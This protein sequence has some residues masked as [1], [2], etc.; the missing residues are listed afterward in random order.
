MGLMIIKDGVVQVERYQYERQ[1]SHRFLSNSMAKSIISLAIG[2]AL[3]EGKI[4]SLDD[5]ANM[6]APKLEGTLFGETT[7]SNLL[8]MASGARYTEEYDGKDDAAASVPQRLAMASRLLRKSLPNGRRRKDLASTGS[9]QT[10][11]LAA[12]L[13]GATGMKRQRISHPPRMAGN[14]R[15]NIGLMACRQNWP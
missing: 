5:R 14:W 7:I 12:V 2:I 13:R 10:H 3:Q 8:R 4:K 1:P 6:Y 9:A 15:R 11:M